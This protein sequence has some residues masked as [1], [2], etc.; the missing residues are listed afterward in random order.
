MSKAEN[1]IRANAEL[2]YYGKVLGFTSADE[3]ASVDIAFEE[4]LTHRRRDN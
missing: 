4:K 1:I 2:A 3:F